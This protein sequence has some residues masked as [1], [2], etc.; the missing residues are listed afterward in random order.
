MGYSRLWK[1]KTKKYT[2][3]ISIIYFFAHEITSNKSPRTSQFFRF[4][5]CKKW[6]NG[7]IIEWLK[8]WCRVREKRHS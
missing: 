4:F 6:P 1:N 3:E 7:L 2:Y 8:G 5:K